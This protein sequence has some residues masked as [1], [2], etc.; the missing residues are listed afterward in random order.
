MHDHPVIAITV[1]EPA[2]IGPELV[3]LVAERH[4]REPFPARLVLVGDAPLLA[5]RAALAGLSPRYRD[6]SPAA[7]APRDG[8]VEIWHQPVTVPVTP[9]H[10][11]PS[12]S[13]HVL[14]M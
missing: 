10:P 1:G 9:G 13:Q 11:D 8:G 12:N 14:E 4:R 5:R 7:P 2:G 3:A 6:Y